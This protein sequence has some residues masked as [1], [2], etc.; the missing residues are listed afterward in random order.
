MAK[1]LTLE[2][3][4][5]LEALLKSPFSEDESNLS[6]TKKLPLIA[7]FLEVSPSTV[8]REV[9]DRGFTYMTYNASKAHAQSL[10]KVSRANTHYQYTQKQKD[11]ILKTFRDF[12]IDKN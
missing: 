4:I 11:L 6:V 3:R 5:R 7:G 1:R 10:E 8:Y 12:A 9:I 2:K